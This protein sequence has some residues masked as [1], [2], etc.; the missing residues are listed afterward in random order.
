VLNNEVVAVLEIAQEWGFAMPSRISEQKMVIVAFLL[1]LGVIIPLFSPVKLAMGPASFTLALHTPIFIAL[2]ISPA[3]AFA[4]TLGT[5]LSFL[6]GGF[7]AVIVSRAA[8]HFIFALL[9]SWFLQVR[10][11][12]LSSFVKTQIFSLVIGLIH[13]WGEVMVVCFFYMNGDMAGAYYTTASALLLVGLGGLA[14]SMVDF[15]VALV[16]LKLLTAP[17]AWRPVFI[18]S[19]IPVTV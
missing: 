8:S 6:I 14:H 4:V 16:A 11:D 13:A 18:T 17:K 12:I 9:G 15:A 2:F 5:T 10:P 7:P 1:A 19:K 3:A